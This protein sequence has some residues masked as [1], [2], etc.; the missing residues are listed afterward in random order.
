MAMVVVEDCALIKFLTSSE[1]RLG[2]THG[3]LVVRS[4]MDI[5]CN[6]NSRKKDMTQHAIPQQSNHITTDFIARNFDSTQ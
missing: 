5:G 2:G 4:Q 1:Y 3:P 6:R